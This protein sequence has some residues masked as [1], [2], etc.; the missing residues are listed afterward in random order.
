MKTIVLNLD[1]YLSAIVRG[2]TLPPL[3][4]LPIA[5]SAPLGEDV[6]FYA[7][8]GEAP[9]QG[10]EQ[11]DAIA[12]TFPTGFYTGFDVGTPVSGILT[13]H[14][15]NLRTVPETS[16]EYTIQC[17]IVS[18]SSASRKNRIIT[19]RLSVERTPR[20]GPVD[21][22]DID[23]LATHERLTAGVRSV[24]ITLDSPTISNPTIS[25]GNITGTSISTASLSITGSSFDLDG[26]NLGLGEAA[27]FE[28][29]LGTSSGS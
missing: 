16:G 24:D 20:N 6:A 14:T 29:V 1:P 13:N 19:F 21:V 10:G 27:M 23:P 12:W 4:S 28:Q 22:V 25:G 15:G 8:S 18:N 26:Y 2:E 5:V 11:I 17:T 7:F 3:P 9:A